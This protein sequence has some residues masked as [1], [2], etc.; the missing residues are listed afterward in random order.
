MKPDE[1]RSL[2]RLRAPHLTR[3]Q[4]LL[5]SCVTVEDWQRAA[6]RSWPRS[7]QDYVEGGA[8][9]E[10]SLARN[11]EAYRRREFLPSVLRDVSRVDTATSLLGAP[12]AL[13]L[14]LAPT[15]YT[16]M[17]HPDGEPAVARAAGAAGVPY[18]LSTVSNTSIEDVARSSDAAHWFQL[19]VWRD[20]GLTRE[21]IDRARE[22][23]YRA[24]MVTVDTPVT[25]NRVRDRHSGFTVP[26][27][28]TV[29][30]LLD[31][32]TRPRWWAGMLRGEPISFANVPAGSADDAQS[33]MELAAAQFDSA[34]TWD[35]LAEVRSQW[36][37]PLM[38][39]GMLRP[40]EI[41]RAAQI[42]IDGVV[43]SNHGGRQLDGT[44]VPLDVLA[45]ARDEVGEDVTVMVDSGIRRG[46]DIAVAIASG[47]DGVLIGRP[48]LYGLGAAGQVGVEAVLRL[49]GEGLERTMALL[50]VSSIEQLRSE[51]PALVASRGACSSE[52]GARA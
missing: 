28:L 31:M 18:T 1:I 51:G 13:P 49:L 20:R 4:R 33:A 16:R 8:E 41:R 3:T 21:L 29:R 11:A 43:L 19:Y 36:S 32:S 37:G 40:D 9:A 24:L 17:M 44:V 14:A 48:Y 10:I 7:I 34:V 50:G 47:A 12:A 15:G 35:D 5:Q 23:G 39:K 27:Q 42:G 25:G 2:V 38:V 30:T 26:P 22:S 45:R 6:H 46:S 52:S